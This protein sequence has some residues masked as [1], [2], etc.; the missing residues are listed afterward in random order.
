MIDWRNLSTD[1][2]LT[3]QSVTAS[4]EVDLLKKKKKAAL[5]HCWSPSVQ[6]MGSQRA[7]TVRGERKSERMSCT[8]N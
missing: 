4:V 1:C 3:H 5:H 6:E 7:N 2:F 8:N